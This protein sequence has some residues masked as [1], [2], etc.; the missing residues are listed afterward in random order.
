MAASPRDSKTP[1]LPTDTNGESRPPN[2]LFCRLDSRPPTVREQRRQQAIASLG[3]LSGQPTPVFE[4]AVQVAAHLLEAPIALLSIALPDRLFLKAC[5]GLSVLGVMNTLTLNREVSREDSFGQYVID[6]QQPLAVADA[7][8][9]SFFCQHPLYQDYGIRAYAGVPLIAPGGECWGTL[10]VWDLEPH[11]FSQRDLDLLALV[12]RWSTSEYRTTVLPPTLVPTPAPLY[13]AAPQAEP[14]LPDLSPSELDALKVQLLAQLTGELR[15]PLTSVMGMARV[16]EQKV[17]GALTDKQQKYLS[18]I[19]TSGEYL[20]S[21]VEEIINLGAIT[22]REVPLHVGAVDLGMLCQQA[23]ANLQPLARQQQQSFQITIEPG[24]RIWPL[25]KEKVRQAIYYLALN[26]IKDSEPGSEIRLHVSRKANSDTHPDLPLHI[27][28]W[29]IHPWLDDGL[30]LSGPARS[31][32]F[33]HL[34]NEAT[35]TFEATGEEEED[36]PNT[37]EAL[38]LLLSYQLLRAHSGTL[39]MQEIAETGYRYICRL[40]QLAALDSQG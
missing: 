3:L 15:A 31:A 26:L 9:D 20:L 2:R 6:S 14:L 30:P 8:S 13:E 37:R 10:A 19:Y 21:L 35:S 25:D 5:F 24:Q 18:I 22:G 36:I 4:E 16:L 1:M 29:A 27:A 32:S 40:P 17:Y 38:G 7:Q 34:V 12:A 33:E 28:L 39:E 11:A 23:I